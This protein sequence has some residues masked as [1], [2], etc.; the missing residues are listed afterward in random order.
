[1]KRAGD[2]KRISQG[3][4][5]LWFQDHLMQDT[6]K[7]VYTAGEACQIVQSHVDRNQ[8]ELAELVELD[9]VSLN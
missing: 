4:K 1:M 2:K 7:T 6:D 3:E 9:R 8:E 5:L